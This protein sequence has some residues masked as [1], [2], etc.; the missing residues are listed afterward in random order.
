MAQWYCLRAG[1]Y[2]MAHIKDGN[3]PLVCLGA[4]A[5]TGMIAAEQQ[6]HRNVFVAQRHVKSLKSSPVHFY[7][8]DIV[9]GESWQFDLML[10]LQELLCKA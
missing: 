5:G 9:W 10:V 7:F 6:K 3:S 2:S 4:K 1:R 8:K